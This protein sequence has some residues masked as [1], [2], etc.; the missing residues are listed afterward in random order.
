MT[1]PASSACKRGI[2]FK[3]GNIQMTITYNDWRIKTHSPYGFV[4]QRH[5]PKINQWRESSYFRTLEQAAHFLFEEQIRTQYD[6]LVID[7]NGS[8]QAAQQLDGLVQ[9]LQEIGKHI[10]EACSGKAI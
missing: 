2:S 3:Q 10:S 9:E 8:I 4:V 6:D 5:K 1:H 7:L